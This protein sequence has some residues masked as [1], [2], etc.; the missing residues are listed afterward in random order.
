MLSFRVLP[1]P[2]IKSILAGKLIAWRSELALRLR[3]WPDLERDAAVGA[4]K[5]EV[6]SNPLREEM[7]ALRLGGADFEPVRGLGDAGRTVL[8]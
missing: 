8:K 6:R 2:L 3:A 7:L 5:L 4:A 1:F